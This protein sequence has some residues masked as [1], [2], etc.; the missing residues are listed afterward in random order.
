MKKLFPYILI[1]LLVGC[2]TWPPTHTIVASSQTIERDTTEQTRIEV[3][4]I[5]EPD[6]ATYRALAE[7]DENNRL[8]IN[9]IDSINGSRIQANLKITED[10]VTGGAIIDFTCREDSLMAEIEHR[11][12][13]IREL[14]TNTNIV[15]KIVEKPLTDWQSFCLVLGKIA[16][17]LVVL[18]IIILIAFKICKYLI[19]R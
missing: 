3:K 5:A 11:D 7:C 1:L 19:K 17:A 10:P 2:R 15:E 9:A 14:E 16:F 13:I 8:L 12:R 6:S 18:S 4:K